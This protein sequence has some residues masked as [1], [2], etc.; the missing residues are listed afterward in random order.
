VYNTTVH[1]STGFTPFELLFGRQSTLPSALK[2]PPET[3]YNYGDYV[4]ELRSRL[5]TVHHH[6]HRNLI[7]GKGKSKEHYDKTSGETKLQVG[8]K[9]LLFDETVRRGRSRTLSA[10]WIGPYKIT[11]IDK[12]NANITRGRKSTKVHV[13]SLK[14]FY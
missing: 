8:D 1:S 5:Q 12:V 2:K 14:P 4:S 3:Q 13:N 11:E 9:V 10:Q 6:A 7:A